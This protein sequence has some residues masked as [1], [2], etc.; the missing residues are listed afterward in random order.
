VIYRDRIPRDNTTHATARAT[1]LARSSVASGADK[2]L[3]SRLRP[4]VTFYAILNKMVIFFSFP[5]ERASR[6]CR[7]YPAC[8]K[9]TE[10]SLVARPNS[11]INSPNSPRAELGSSL[12]IFRLFNDRE[13]RPLCGTSIPPL[14]SSVR[15]IVSISAWKE[16]T[17]LHSNSSI[18]EERN[19]D[20]HRIVRL[21]F[22][23]R[24]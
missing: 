12:R 2:R 7:R 23:S 13:N 11:K 10:I 8:R 6:H 20:R 17:R 3:R 18:S 14:S 5:R 1:I 16:C 24:L 19:R 15:E 21:L 4:R 9:F 22:L